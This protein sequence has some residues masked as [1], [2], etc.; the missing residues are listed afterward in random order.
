M[1]SIDQRWISAAAQ[2]FLASRQHWCFP[3]ASAST[4]LLIANLIV[5]VAAGLS[6]IVGL[7]TF[8]APHGELGLR[9]QRTF[10]ASDGNARSARLA[11][12]ATARP[13]ADGSSRR[14]SPNDRE[15]GQAENRHV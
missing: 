8:A 15:N 3:L 12:P 13:D 11:T 14:I 4:K 6:L 1:A 7:W 10:S 2:T 5:S 9:T